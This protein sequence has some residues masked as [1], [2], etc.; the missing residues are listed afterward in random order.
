M[1]ESQY[2]RNSHLGQVGLVMVQ[3][4]STGSWAW[5]LVIETHQASKEQHLVAVGVEV[6]HLFQ[7]EVDIGLL[8]RHPFHQLMATEVSVLD[9]ISQFPPVL[10]RSSPNF[11]S[12][13]VVLIGS[14]VGWVEF[15]H[16]VS[17][18]AVRITLLAFQLAL[19][20]LLLELIPSL[21]QVAATVDSLYDLVLRFIVVVPRYNILTQIGVS[22][23][24]LVVA[25]EYA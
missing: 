24:M 4:A 6:Q 13:S 12:A 18:A 3:Q 15:G 22:A 25:F 11:P 1:I 8:S 23:R 19:S 10:A 5:D 17:V 20:L 9:E 7:L 16:K 14:K 21:S 2:P